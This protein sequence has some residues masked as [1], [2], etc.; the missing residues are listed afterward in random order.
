MAASAVGAAP[1]LSAAPATAAPASDTALSLVLLGG[2]S[3]PP[4]PKGR[5]VWACRKPGRMLRRA[6]LM[7][8][9]VRRGGAR[10]G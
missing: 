7:H 1:L 6:D 4:T 10:R 9:P 8:V 3:G 5:R 2:N